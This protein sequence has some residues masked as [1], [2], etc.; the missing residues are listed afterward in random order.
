MEQ[1]SKEKLEYF[2]TKDGKKLFR[3]SWLPEKEPKAVM[4]IVHGF[5]EYCDRYH[6][7]AQYLNEFGYAVESFDLRGHGH[8]DGI[9]TYVHSFENLLDDLDIFLEQCA[10]KYPDKPIF[11]FGHSMGG[12]IVS[13]FSITRQ[14]DIAGILL[15]GASIKVSD[16]ISP[17]L[18]KLSKIL[19]KIVPKMQTIKLKSEHISHDPE[20]VKK[21]D[22]DP[23]VYRGGVLAR[24][25]AELNKATEK[26]QAQMGKFKLP[27]L[28]MH[29]DIDKL[30]DCDGSKMFYDHISSQDKT[31][32]LYEGF[33]HEI[34]NEIGKDKVLRDISD[35][36]EKRA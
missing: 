29:G 32:K 11:M 25:G 21:Y 35:W 13:L 28:I 34:V 12:A 17:T 2:I 20:I 3:K 18:V 24:T 5:A 15:S 14:P 10:E 31:L 30:A 1:Q 23:L 8:S 22:N 16:E 6:H 33:Y 9:R 7:V 19:G 27:V 26:I 4:I 36:L